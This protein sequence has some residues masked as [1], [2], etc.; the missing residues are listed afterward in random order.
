MVLLALYPTQVLR[1]KCV[2]EK[3][4]S[5]PRYLE[6]RCKTEYSLRQLFLESVI[7]FGFFWEY[8]LGYSSKTAFE[9][10][11]SKSSGGLLP[12]HSTWLFFKKILIAVPK[13]DPIIFCRHDTFQL[14]PLKQFFDKKNITT[15]CNISWNSCQESYN[16]LKP[17]VRML[18]RFL[19]RAQ[20]I[21]TILQDLAK[22][23]REK[24]LTFSPEKTTKMV[25]GTKKLL[26][27]NRSLVKKSKEF[28][29]SWQEIR[30]NEE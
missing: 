14:N 15:Q 29:K 17:L 3:S 19:P 9:E 6:T 23:L 2:P 7:L 5:I 20:R 22:D 12:N 30:E 25:F 4:H 21:C 27:K 18:T 11:Q 16:F 10:I 1:S 13:L 8:F 26:R 28:Q 24:Y